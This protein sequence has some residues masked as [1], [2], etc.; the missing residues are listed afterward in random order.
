MEQKQKEDLA[1]LQGERDE[2][3]KSIAKIEHKETQYKHEIKSREMQVQKLQD[4]IK[5]KLFD[6]KQTKE[7]KAPAGKENKPDAAN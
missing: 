3:L 1:K 4:Q 5:S 7:T 2:L 6:T